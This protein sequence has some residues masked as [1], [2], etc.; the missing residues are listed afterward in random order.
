MSLVKLCSVGLS[1]N[2]L[3]LKIYCNRDPLQAQSRLSYD[4]TNDVS[5]SFGAQ[6]ITVTDGSLKDVNSIE[7]S[8]FTG[9][10][11]VTRL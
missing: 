7:N 6:S 3:T 11:E 4:R 10:M 1:V 9:T 2:N 8:S 5:F